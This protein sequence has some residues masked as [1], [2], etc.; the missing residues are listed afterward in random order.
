MDAY[1]KLIEWPETPEEEIE[2]I[3]LSYEEDD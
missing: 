3:S 2:E 1:C